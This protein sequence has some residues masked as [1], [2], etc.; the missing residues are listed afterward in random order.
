MQLKSPNL[1][2]GFSK[3]RGVWNVLQLDAQFLAERL[4]GLSR[5]AIRTTLSGGSKQY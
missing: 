2:S 1:S 5:V 4:I 3:K